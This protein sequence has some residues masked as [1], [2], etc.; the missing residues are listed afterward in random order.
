MNND[1]TKYLD[2]L[3]GDRIGTVVI[4]D[5]LRDTVTSKLGMLRHTY[6]EWP[7]QRDDIVSH[8]ERVKHTREVYT[9]PVLLGTHCVAKTSA[10]FTPLPAMMAYVDCDAWGDK[11]ASTEDIAAVREFV[12]THGGMIVESGSD[13]SVHAYAPLPGTVDSAQLESLNRRFAG[14]FHGDAKWSANSLLRVPGTFNH[15]HSPARPVTLSFVGNGETATRAQTDILSWPDDDNE[16]KRGD[17]AFNVTKL[18]TWVR[19]RFER[20]EGADRSGDFWSAVKS[21][22]ESNVDMLD[23]IRACEHYDIGVD[24]YGS[25]LDEQ[26]RIAYGDVRNDML[27]YEMSDLGNAER[28]VNVYA[29]RIMWIPELSTWM[30][31][32]G[33]RWYTDTDKMVDRMLTDLTKS[34]MTAATKLNADNAQLGAA[35]VSFARKTQS[36]RSITAIME[37]SKAFV[38]VS[39]SKLDSNPDLLS[40]GN[41]TLNL[42]S[43]VV[44]PSKPSDYI[45]MGTDVEYDPTA[46]CPQ[47]LEWLDWFQKGDAEVIA[48]L[49]YLVGQSLHGRGENRALPFLQGRP[50]SG[51]TT[52]TDVVRIL[53]GQYAGTVPVT[54]FA[55]NSDF[56]S[57]TGH[58]ADLAALAGKRYVVMSETEQDQRLNTSA[59]NQITGGDVMQVSGK[60][61]KPFIL[62]NKAITLWMHGNHKPTFKGMSNDGIWSRIALIPCNAKRPQGGKTL[63]HLSETLVGKEGPG[64]LAWAVRGVNTHVDVPAS[65]TGATTAYMKETDHLGQYIDE[66]I[67]VTNDDADFVTNNQLAGS[68]GQWV[69]NGNTEFR[70]KLRN[71]GELEPVGTLLIKAL[72]ALDDE[73]KVA[74][75]RARVNGQVQRGVQ[76]V[77][78]KSPSSD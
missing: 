75:H 39:I 18:P 25:R 21:C 14:H 3:H 68:V 52:F 27:K 72:T 6:F 74:P 22:A 1:T 66:R 55:G 13:N 2:R 30:V 62:D 7:A 60:G 11:G 46:E 5:A 61:T 36:Y 9:V 71:T 34:L 29:N 12:T 43:G 10:D 31:W 16:R 70:R 38:S 17:V 40:V 42:R 15:K 57:T 32:G 54:Y 69:A 77:R 24:K 58:T 41:G 50:G 78:F 76:G 53:M 35:W 65:L 26:V 23:A 56:K 48:Y 73:C 37:L 8:V 33:N 49:Q 28:F 51:K 59:L 67:E 45:T 47:W 20:A 4:V 63:Y 44:Y 19:A 64:I